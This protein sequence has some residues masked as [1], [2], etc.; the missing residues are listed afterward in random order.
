MIIKGKQTYVIDRSGNREE[1]KGGGVYSILRKGKKYTIYNYNSPL[2]Q[3]LHN[4][5]F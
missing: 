4:I 1:S 3:I 2:K 5:S